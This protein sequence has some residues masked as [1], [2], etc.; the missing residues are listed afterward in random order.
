MSYVIYIVEKTVI[1][2]ASIQAMQHECVNIYGMCVRQW[3]YC[4]TS[5]LLRMRSTRL[6]LRAS[7]DAEAMLS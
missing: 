3:Y 5:E 4:H 2:H 1:N 7:A 6:D